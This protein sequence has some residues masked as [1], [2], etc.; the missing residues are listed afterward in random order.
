MQAKDDVF[1]FVPWHQDG[2]VGMTPMAVH[3]QIRPNPLAD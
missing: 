1:G 3:F 2:G